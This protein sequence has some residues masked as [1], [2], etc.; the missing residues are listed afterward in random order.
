MALTDSELT[1][2]RDA[3]GQLLPQSCN[4]LSVTLT[5]DGQGGNTETW[6]T[7]SASVDCRLDVISGTEQVTGGGLQPY[8]KVMLSLPYDTD[9]DTD[10][11]VELG[12]NTYAVLTANIDQA[13]IAV[14]RCELEKL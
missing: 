7:A 10:N 1:A 13:W 9:I 8:T 12:S 3:I 14:R 2:M 11:R 6:G 4:I 5:P